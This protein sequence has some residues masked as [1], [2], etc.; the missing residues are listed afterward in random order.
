MSL[1][2]GPGGL[3]SDFVGTS[4]KRGTVNAPSKRTRDSV[5]HANNIAELYLKKETERKEKT[6]CQSL[7]DQNIVNYIFCL[8]VLLLGKCHSSICNI[9]RKVKTQS[10]Y[11]PTLC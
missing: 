1:G 5:S 7:P 6:F 11:F 2:K 9:H 8:F 4:E 3:Q 10:S